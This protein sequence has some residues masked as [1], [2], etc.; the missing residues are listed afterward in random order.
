MSKLEERLSA[1]VAEQLNPIQERFAQQ[2][3]QAL[4]DS[5]TS[6]IDDAFTELLKEHSDLPENAREGIESLAYRYTD[7]PGLSAKEVVEKGFADYQQLLGQG[8]KNLFAS[9]SGQ[10]QTPEGPGAASMQDEKLTSFDDPRLRE[11]AK[12]I[13]QNS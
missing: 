7:E 8:E 10:P 9:K 1:K 2:D 3:Q 12:A 13:L 6:E 11:R 4:I 5:A